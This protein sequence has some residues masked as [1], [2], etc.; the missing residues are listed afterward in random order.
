[1]IFDELS[2]KDL[3][4]TSETCRAMKTAVEGYRKTAFNLSKLLEPFIPGES[5]T[6][7]RKLLL[8]TGGLISG[9]TALQF[10]DRAKY[11]GSDLDF[12]VNH[13]NCSE[14][15]AW[16]LKNGMKRVDRVHESPSHEIDTCEGYDGSGQVHH[17][18]E[19]E[20]RISGETRSIQIIAT[21]GKPILAVLKF[22]SC[23]HVKSCLPTVRIS[24]EISS[25]C[26]EFHY[27]R[28]SGVPISLLDIL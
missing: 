20:A 12:Y 13:E 8:S 24:N 17:I 15:S 25:V 28:E 9:S 16:L 2:I 5:T 26:N 11:D 6:S 14:A 1:M 21:K 18:E 3:F 27:A 23:K 7:F 19:Y 22:H 4:R 10:L